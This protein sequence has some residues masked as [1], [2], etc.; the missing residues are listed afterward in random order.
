M[1]VSESILLQMRGAAISGA[2]LCA[3]VILVLVQ[4]G[5]RSVPQLVAL[6][7]ASLGVPAWLAA[8]QYV[9]A[10]IT[11]G[12]KSYGHYKP[13]ASGLL[14]IAGIL[15]LFVAFTSLVWFVSPCASAAF[16]LA[17]LI[18]ALFISMHIRAVSGWPCKNGPSN[19]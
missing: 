16:A 1:P 8:W 18:A 2:G 13:R 10:Y 14:A 9:Q 12:S 5:V 7:G 6:W 4:T 19:A 3:A 11:W 17:C 15:P